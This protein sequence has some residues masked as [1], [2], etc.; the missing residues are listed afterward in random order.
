MC[1]EPIS[2]VLPP[3]ILGAIAQNGTSE[4]RA[5]ALGV[6]ACDAGL[7]E[8]RSRTPARSTAADVVRRR[9]PVRAIF[10]AAGSAAQP[11]TGRKL[12]GEGDQPTGDAAADEAYDGLGATYDLYLETYDRDSIDG[13]G[14]EL[15]AYVHF[16]KAYANAFWDG[17]RMVFG[18]GDGRVVRRMT[19]SVDVIGHE[20]THGVISAE[21]GLVYRG[22]S[23]A[24]NESIADAFGSLVKQRIRGET[25][26]HA[27]WLIGEGVFADGIKA[28]ALRSMLE[29]G[30][31]YDDPLL[32][33]DPQ[34][35]TF[36]DYRE[37]AED[38]GG[39]HL[40]SG[41]PNRAFALAA[42][43]LGGP[44]WEGVGRV[45]YAA[46]RHEELS[47][48]SG[49]AAFAELSSRVAGDVLGRDGAAAVSDAW[50]EVG[51]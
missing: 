14:L 25:A 19:K 48:T 8:T 40:N 34:P 29:P 47:P 6:L 50:R 36:N 38:N 18:D 1:H 7:R 46:L 22:Q 51:L 45:W 31:A 44:A 42:T 32:G 37:T 23:G 20:L 35:S 39:V 27:D 5:W 21:A 43:R 2:C 11:P 28:R 30:T 4:Q 12:R 13:A 16:G 17:A 41:I 9:T 49:F 15:D 33:R 10:D 24:L 26:E 3:Y